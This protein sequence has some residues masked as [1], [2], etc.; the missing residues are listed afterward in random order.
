V[1]F[2]GA[3]I[4]EIHAVYPSYDCS[5]GIYGVVSYGVRQQA[6]E[7]GIRL[8]LGAAPAEV[9]SLVLR[10]SLALVLAGTAIGVTGGFAVG[11]LMAG[12]LYGV[13][14]ADLPSFAA[15]LAMMSLIALMACYVPARRAMRTD[16]IVTLRT[17]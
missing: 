16:P 17:D 14:P 10:R 7:F 3:N 1:A 4:P 2:S 5:A 12:L 8:A 6:R 11:Y 15:P 9:L 13:S